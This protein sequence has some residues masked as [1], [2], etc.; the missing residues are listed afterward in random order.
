[1]RYNEKL[2][3]VSDVSIIHISCLFMCVSFYSSF[4]RISAYAYNSKS[5][6]HCRSALGP[7][8]S[9]LL[10]YYAPLVCVPPVIGVLTVWRHNKPKTEKVKMF[11]GSSNR[12]MAEDGTVMGPAHR[13]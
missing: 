7:G 2:I 9:G 12:G 4:V 13:L 5:K 3:T 1:M 10:Y 11:S 8:A 6:V